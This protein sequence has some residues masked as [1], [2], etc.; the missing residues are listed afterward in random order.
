MLVGG[1]IFC[2]LW[3]L[4]LL[5]K[6]SKQESLRLAFAGSIS[7]CLMDCTTFSLDTINCRSKVLGEKLVKNRAE[8]FK[9]CQNLHRGVSASFYGS[10]FYGYAYFYLYHNF[11]RILLPFYNNQT[12]PT[13]YMA[14]A[15][16]AESIALSVYFP[17]ELVKLRMQTS[18]E[19][20]NYKSTWDG[21]RKIK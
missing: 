16:L 15:A 19:R 4:G 3:T 20:Y 13:Y 9:A 18:N 21:F 11:K 5:H 1:S 7:T 14:S 2:G 17:F 10:L 8:A 6:Q 12:T